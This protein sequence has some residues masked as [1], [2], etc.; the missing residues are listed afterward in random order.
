VFIG[1][2]AAGKS[3]IGKRVARLL[4]EPFVDT[5]SVI[6]QR[7]GAIAG[8]FAN[9]GESGFRAIERE[10]VGES[11]ERPGVVSLG[12][13]AVLDPVTQ[14]RLAGLP[15]VL[16][17]STPEAVEA[18]I[19]GSARPLLAEGGIQAWIDLLEQRRPVYE[20][21]A[22]TTVDTSRLPADALAASIAHWVRT[23]RRTRE[24]QS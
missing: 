18:R 8:I 1:P 4:G 3:R 13:G 12:G 10:I 16:L 11:L 14:E 19:S 23:D 2:M 6:V 20:R 24:K 5:D 17:M 21:L 7:H 15:V 22:S 9:A